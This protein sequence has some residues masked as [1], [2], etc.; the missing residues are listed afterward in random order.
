MD[1]IPIS[2]FNDFVFCPYSVY[3][4]NIFKNTSNDIYKALP[5]MRGLIAHEVTDD[6]RN[7]TKDKICALSVC[8]VKMGIFGRIDTYHKETGLLVERKYELKKIYKGQIYQL[9]AQYFCMKEMGYDVKLLE[10]YEMSRNK[11][12]P[13]NIPNESEKSELINFI[14]E[15][16]NFNPESYCDINPN[17]C[18]HCIYCNLCDKGSFV[19][20]Y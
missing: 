3:L 17:K 6:I 9:W 13:I 18:V 1:Y 15:F 12:Y 7:N 10:F 5:Q 14:S 11:K 2:N 16:K 8:S 19:N 20:V 4:D